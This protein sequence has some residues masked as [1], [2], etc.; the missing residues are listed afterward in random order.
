MQWHGFQAYLLE[1][2]YYKRIAVCTEKEYNI[3]ETEEIYKEKR[4]IKRN[5]KKKSDR[6]N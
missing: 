4:S 3:K 5:I 1:S 6:E 2:I